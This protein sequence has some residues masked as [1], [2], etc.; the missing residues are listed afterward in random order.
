MKARKCTDS[1]DAS[2]FSG[3]AKMLTTGD[4][5]RGRP[6]DQ[7]RRALQW[8]KNAAQKRQDQRDRRR[9]FTNPG[10]TQFEEDRERWRKHGQ[11]INRGNPRGDPYEPGYGDPFYARNR[12]FSPWRGNNWH[13]LDYDPWDGK[14]DYDPIHGTHY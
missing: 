5:L 9:K 8:K 4:N 6:L 11:A 7:D 3:F 13:A 14:F 2:R 10:R 12:E 1:N